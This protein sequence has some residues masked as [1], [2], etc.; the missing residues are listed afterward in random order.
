MVLKRNE[1]PY[2]SEEKYLCTVYPA[3]KQHRVLFLPSDSRA[4][5]IRELVHS[6]LYD[7]MDV[8]F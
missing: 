2:E 8:N 3:G 4:E 6:D 1:I 5:S 7:P